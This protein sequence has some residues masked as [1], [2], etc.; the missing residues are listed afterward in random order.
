[1]E[2]KHPKNKE[3]TKTSE[4]ECHV[5]LKLFI[6]NQRIRLNGQ[7]MET[8]CKKIC[9]SNTAE[10]CFSP[11]QK[12]LLTTLANQLRFHKSDPW[13]KLRLSV[14]IIFGL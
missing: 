4:P 2:A 7:K 13:F 12:V 8:T 11:K 5:K 9:C 10:S 1:M 3:E 14:V 6:V